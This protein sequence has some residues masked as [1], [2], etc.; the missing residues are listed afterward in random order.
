MIQRIKVFIAASID[1][2]IADKQGGIDWLTEMPNPDNSDLGYQQFM[3]NIDAI[4]MGRN[5]FETVCGFE[6]DW[7][8]T[9]PVYV[10]SNTLT[11]LPEKYH[12]K[13]TLVSGEIID[14]IASIRK[15]G[16]GTLYVDGGGTIQ[17]FMKEDRID[18]FI[19][20]QIPILLGDGIPLFKSMAKR[21]DFELTHSEVFLGQLV[22]S[23]YQRKR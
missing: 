16:H 18:D 23:H 9:Q 2:F 3:T 12:D 7:P 6:M 22:Q 14:V 8:Y 4:I 1:G 19:I 10:L 17:S 13:A 15:K 11:Q 5:T 20:T 21:L